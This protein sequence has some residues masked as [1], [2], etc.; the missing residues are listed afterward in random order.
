MLKKI[1]QL[2]LQKTY[3]SW[4]L[5]L[6]ISLLV[7]ILFSFNS[8]AAK[9]LT[10]DVVV[11][12]SDPEGIS[13]AVSAARLGKKVLLVDIRS[14]VGGL[15]TS[16]ML[17]MLDL[18]YADAENT[19]FVNNG[20]FGE[21][22]DSVCDSGVFDIGEA[23]KHF[24]DLI[25]KNHIMLILN[26]SNFKPI[27]SGKK[28][29]GLSFTQGGK[30]ITVNC[31]ILIDGSQDAKVA[32]LAGV[33]YTVGRE[34]LGLKGCHAAATLIFSVKGVNWNRVRSYLN[35]DD[36]IYTGSTSKA[37][38]GYS[39]MLD[40]QPL[41]LDAQLRALN[42]AL[43]KDGSVVINALQIFGGDVLS[44]DYENYI[45]MKAKNE[46]PKVISYLQKNAPG[47]EKARLYKVA[48][49]IYIRE[50]V[51][52]IGEDRL[53]GEDIFTNKDFINKIA[54]GSYP[55]DLQATK[56]DYL[57]G[58]I[59]ASRNLYSI[60]LGVTIPKE[61]D[62]L[63]VV[64]RSA[65]YDTIAH[66]S[67]RTVPVGMAVAQ[68]AGITA[69]YCVDY[70][71]TP[72]EVNRDANHFKEIDRLLRAYSVTLNMPLPENEEGD[73]WYWPYIRRLR[74]SA[75]LSKEYNYNNDYRIGHPAEFDTVERIRKLAEVNSNIPVPPHLKSISHSEWLTKD[76]L[77]AVANEF[78]GENF[79]SFEQLYKDG[80]I[81][82]VTLEKL[83][84]ATILNHEHV[85]AVMD[86]VLYELRKRNNLYIPSLEEII[87][88][89]V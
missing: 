47:F 17:C 42:M 25:H 39:N 74:S 7:P 16:G 76:W 38:W 65:S 53:T 18:N 55:L 57:G 80:I 30:A 86:Q 56:R 40:Y 22:Y 3:K 14:E 2:N 78:L 27:L 89:D 85:Y 8:Y 77:L 20:I 64:G 67:A 82:A 23:K 54:Y 71:V 63:L 59:L 73:E 70:D 45:Y 60:P 37:A 68:A 50:G 35:E 62:N 11:V 46:L 5:L 87:R 26:A 83:N 75:L 29:T 28:V 52:I 34:D 88:Y 66:S 69:A 72:R 13:S 12:G 32:R 51:H 21:F 6:L 33:P 84:E 9:T 4:V 19:S 58:N 81:D 43:Q 41:S 1:Y 36:S 61:I 48:S 31:K 15:Y 44:P 24:M 49:E 10:Y 79:L